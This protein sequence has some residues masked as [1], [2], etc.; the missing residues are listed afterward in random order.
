MGSMGSGTILES[1]NITQCTF[2]N[3]RPGYFPSFNSIGLVDLGT[4]N[5]DSKV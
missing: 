4:E 1:G 2:N 3:I 5:A